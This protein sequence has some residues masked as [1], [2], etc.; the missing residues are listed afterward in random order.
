MYNGYYGTRYKQSTLPPQAPL[1]PVIS[2]GKRACLLRWRGRYSWGSQVW[3]S[4]N[5]PPWSHLRNQPWARPGVRQRL[6]PASGRQLLRPRRQQGQRP[7]CLQRR[8][9]PR[10]RSRSHCLQVMWLAVPPNLQIQGPRTRLVPEILKRIRT[11]LRLAQTTVLMTSRTM[12]LDSRTN[13]TLHSQTKAGPHL[14]PLVSD[15][16]L[17]LNR[18]HVLPCHQSC[19]GSLGEGRLLN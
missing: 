14:W 11:S 9:Q 2:C 13:T 7:R 12:R 10:R 16:C 8:R 1:V 3:P 19:V 18:T 6:L 5:L 15:L 17:A 4:P